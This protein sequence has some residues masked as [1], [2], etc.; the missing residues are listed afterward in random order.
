MQS[1]WKAALAVGGLAVVGAFVFWSLYKKWLT[2]PIFSKLSSDQTFY[3]MLIF[4]IFT[5]VVFIVCAVVYAISNKKG[6]IPPAADSAH[7]FA[8]HEA[9]KGVN[10]IDCEQLIGP[11]VTNAA[12][13]L[14]ITASSWLNGLVDHHT[15]ISN[16]FDDYELLFCV[17]VKCDKIVPGFERRGVKCKE[18]V[19]DE[20][21]QAYQ[22][23]KQYKERT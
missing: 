19:S 18:F 6:N 12:R 1:F 10:E 9:W 2:L 15:I 13:A 7:V 21:K 20:M 3:L 16:H 23:M 22:Q 11:D 4:L 5:F 14:T 8:L 17:M